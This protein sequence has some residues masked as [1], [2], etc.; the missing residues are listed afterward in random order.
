M[1]AGLGAFIVA[2]VVLVHGAAFAGDWNGVG[3]EISTCFHPL[4]DFVSVSWGDWAQA[5]EH[6]RTRDGQIRYRPPTNHVYRMDFS[7]QVRQVD[8]D[9][10]VRVV[11]DDEND[12]GPMG[13]SPS[14]SLR[15]WHSVG[16]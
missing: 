16:N 13:P 9:T 3:E 6:T 1:K 10:M 8:G 14:C 7:F 4:S 2:A 12:N 15:S 5:G 11:P